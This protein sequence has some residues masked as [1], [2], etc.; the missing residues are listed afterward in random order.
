MSKR[1][2][3]ATASRTTDS[4]TGTSSS[5]STCSPPKA[6]SS[7]ASAVDRAPDSSL[8]DTASRAR[9]DAARANP[10]AGLSRRGR[11]SAVPTRVDTVVSV[12]TISMS[13]SGV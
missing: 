3:A 4:R 12:T 7:L 6:R 11:A 5:T 2:P 9:A 1:I 13:W 8:P 10:S